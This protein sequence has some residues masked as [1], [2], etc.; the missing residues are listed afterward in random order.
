MINYW[1]K[2]RQLKSSQVP[3]YEPST[4]AE[5][6]EAEDVDW[7]GASGPRIAWFPFCSLVLAEGGVSLSTVQETGSGKPTKQSTMEKGKR[8]LMFWLSEYLKLFHSQEKY[9]N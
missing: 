3:E 8:K 2:V 6:S 5:F 7:G 1:K 4:L 9:P